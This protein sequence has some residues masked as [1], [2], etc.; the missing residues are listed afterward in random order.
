MSI[1]NLISYG[2]LLLAG[3]A[4]WGQSVEDIIR[5]LDRMQTFDTLYTEGTMISTD[6]FGEKKSTYRAWS[7]M[8]RDFL[9]EFT[10]IE[11][12]GQKVLRVNDDLYLFYPDAEDIIP[13]HG[14][15]LKQSLFGDVS[16]EDITEGRNTL[17]KYDV[18]LMGSEAV[19]GLD[20][21]KIE[22][23]AVSKDVPYPKQV[24]YVSKKDNILRAAEYYAR[25]GRLLKL[26]D[27]RKIETF[28]DG[29]VMLMEVEIKDQLRRGSSTLMRTDKADINPEL[30]DDLFSLRSLY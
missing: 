8:S 15:A 29:R 21:W 1:R 4:V 12:R 5:E 24:I 28:D 23:I 7:R 30:S 3:A 22:M 19:K 10:N 25:S 18:S 9:I 11:E 2:L 13:M 17:D 20:C 14:S 26:M 16:Y 6:R 27:V